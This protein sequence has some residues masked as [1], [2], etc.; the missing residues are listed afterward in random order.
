MYGYGCCN[1][2][3]GVSRYSLSVSG[4]YSLFVF[5]NQIIN[6]MSNVDDIE[7]WG[8][9][10]NLSSGGSC[11][12]LSLCFAVDLRE[13]TQETARHSENLVSEGVL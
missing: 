2:E 1:S 7:P 9:C 13:N 10:S 12:Y 11:V 8:S 3:G 5:A 6:A 4:V